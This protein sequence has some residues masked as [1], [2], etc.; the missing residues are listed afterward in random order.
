MPHAHPGQGGSDL[1]G[2]TWESNRGRREGQ[3]AS[4]NQEDPEKNEQMEKPSR[5]HCAITQATVF[6]TSHQAC[7]H[8]HKRVCVCVCVCVHACL[9]VQSCLTLCYP[10]DC[11][12]QAPLSM[13]FSRQ[14]Y[15]SE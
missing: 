5:F 4:Q 13:G 14:E 7:A 9:V 11:T 8:R 2:A 6:P 12:C 15:W 1:P 10:M 3:E